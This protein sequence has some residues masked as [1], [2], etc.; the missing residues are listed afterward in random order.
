MPF[1]RPDILRGLDFADAAY[2]S[3]THHNENAQAIVTEWRGAM[4]IGIAGTD[5]ILDV[6]ND[7]SA[8]CVQRDGMGHVADGLADYYDLTRHML[9]SAVLKDAREK[10]IIGHSLGGP[11]AMMYARYLKMHG[12]KVRGI[13][14]CSPNMGQQDFC[15]GFDLDWVNVIYGCDRIPRLPF[16]L[17]RPPKDVF[18]HSD[19]KD[20]PAQEES[21]WN[22]VRR[23]MTLWDHK[24]DRVRAGV[25]RWVG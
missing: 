1:T 3:P 5:Q 19:G 9:D 16:W 23:I 4:V 15:K 8:L 24:L 17:H 20:R 25:K 11:A 7:L 18:I 12:H 2:T 22:P 21:G 13:T 6:I 14:Y 10:I